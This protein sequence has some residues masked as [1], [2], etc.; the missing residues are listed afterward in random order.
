MNVLVRF[1]IALALCLPSLTTAAES[2]PVWEPIKHRVGWWM[3]QSRHGIITVTMKNTGL[4]FIAFYRCPPGSTRMMTELL[5]Y[6]GDLYSS[7]AINC[8]GQPDIENVSFHIDEDFF[9]S[10]PILVRIHY[11]ETA[12]ARNASAE[13]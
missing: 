7:Y 2:E 9:A 6:A 3:L 13:K 10:L 8:D 11:Y 4:Q 5:W 1:L 12:L